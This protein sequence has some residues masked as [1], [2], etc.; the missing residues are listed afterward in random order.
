MAMQEN[1]GNMSWRLPFLKQLA[2]HLDCSIMAPRYAG[3]HQQGHAAGA[4]GLLHLL[5]LGVVPKRAR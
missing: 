5:A 4:H 2:A 3:Y 1:A